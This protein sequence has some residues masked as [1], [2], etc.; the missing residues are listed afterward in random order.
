MRRKHGLAVVDGRENAVPSRSMQR[1]WLRQ[2]RALKVVLWWRGDGDCGLRGAFL[3][4]RLRDGLRLWRGLLLDLL[5]LVM[6]YML[7]LLLLCLLLLDLLLLS[8]LLR[9]VLLVLLLR[10]LLLLLLLNSRRH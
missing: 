8:L 2:W 9:L 3:L 6:L 5:L 1:P 7:L 10:V 4:L